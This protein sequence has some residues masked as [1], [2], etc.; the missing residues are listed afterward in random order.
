MSLAVFDG[1]G[2]KERTYRFNMKVNAI[3]FHRRTLVKPWLLCTLAIALAI[4]SAVAVF[5]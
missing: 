4:V 3:P 5:V 1:N 2:N